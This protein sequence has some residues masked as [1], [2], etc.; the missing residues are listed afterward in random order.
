M[1]LRI[2]SYAAVERSGRGHRAAG[3]ALWRG[4]DEG[5]GRSVLLLVLPAGAAA[6]VSGQVEALAEVCH[7][8]LLP[9]DDVVS[10][11]EHV[12]VVSPWPRGGRLSELL[13]RHGPLTA[14]ETLTVLI[15]L[16]SALATVHGHQVR[17]GGVCPGS[18]WFDDE[19]RP[20][21]GA[22]ATARIVALYQLGMPSDSRDVAPEVVRGERFQRDP[23]GPAADVFS[24][25]S[26]ALFCLTGRSAWPAD[27]PAD[28]LIQ[29][30]AGVWPD[31][32][33]GAGP[34]ALLDLVRSM[35]E[36]APDR[37]PSAAAAA[38]RLSELGRPEPIRFGAR[39]A[40][41][42]GSDDRW[43]GATPSAPAARP[44]AASASGPALG[45][46]SPL[47]RA[48]IALLAT[49]LVAVVV[50]Q[51]AVWTHGAEDGDHNPAAATSSPPAGAAPDWPQIVTDLDNARGRALA[52]A[53]PAL[54]AEVY[55]DGS[56][57]AQAD[58]ALI[59]ELSDRGWH[60]SDGLHEISSV[61]P[62]D[63][64]ALG[65]PD[66]VRLAVQDRLPPRPILDRSGTQVGMTPA[67][68]QQERVVLL[69]RTPV[70]YRIAGIADP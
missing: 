24:L 64:V 48:G 50:V 28:V 42:A 36:R 69:T 34:P 59:G 53:D 40:L 70:G 68:E 47:V 25:G 13:L 19:G 35:L 58:A 57:M 33:D 49:L 4:E 52:A 56:A 31:P 67:R 26:V 9:V 23:P 66:S 7:P 54:L 5:T 44:R 27:D 43:R 21:L 62:V 14:S 1:T 61:T 3:S 60:V 45:G 46:P 55:V 38:Q 10:D 16:A 12:A 6:P 41:A 39:P 18:I 20:Q 17:H 2:G 8:H 51:A 15:P 32:P 63:A 37:R 65:E 29:S 22:L 11:E 30:A